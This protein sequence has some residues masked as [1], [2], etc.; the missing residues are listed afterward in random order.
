LLQ[1][2]PTGT[3]KVRVKYYASHQASKA[4]GTTSVVLWTF[5][6]VGCRQ[7][8]AVD[9]RTVRLSTDSEMM[10]V[11][12]IRFP[13]GC[14]AAEDVAIFESNTSSKVIGHLRAGEVADVEL[15][16][17]TKVD[18]FT[19]VPLKTGGSVQQKYL[20]PMRAEFDYVEPLFD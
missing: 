6:N 17:A 20:E 13:E 7:A 12:N 14:V 3:F 1:K 15:D 9:F 11:L 16:R 19:M 10:D 2:V 4:T 8:A 18:G 5:A